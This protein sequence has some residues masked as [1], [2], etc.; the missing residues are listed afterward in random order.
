MI[1]AVERPARSLERPPNIERRYQTPLPQ[2][3]K[4][5]NPAALPTKESCA[6]GSTGV[7]NVKKYSKSASLSHQV[8][9]LAL[10]DW[11]HVTVRHATAL[12]CQYVMR[13]Y[14][15]SH[16]TAEVIAALTGLGMGTAR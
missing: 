1:T 15:V 12:A 3:P 7:F 2:Q 11:R 13:R 10:F 6:P 4:T 16:D 5:Q 9:G 14:G 8:S